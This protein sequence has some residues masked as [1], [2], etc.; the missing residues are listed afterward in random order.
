M[1]DQIPEKPSR[2][3]RI[4]AKLDAIHQLLVGYNGKAPGLLHRM[5]KAEEEI[6][7]VK[8]RQGK[9]SVAYGTI[10]AF[11]FGMGLWIGKVW[12]GTK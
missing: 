10:S 2:I 12:G 8:S 6:D 1:P 4:E 9:M 11:L 5:D 3:G 7:G